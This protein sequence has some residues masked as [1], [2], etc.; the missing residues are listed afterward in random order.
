MEEFGGLVGEKTVRSPSCESTCACSTTSTGGCASSP[1]PL[2]GCC[3]MAASTTLAS[4]TFSF[5]WRPRLFAFEL[6]ISQS[7]LFPTKIL[8]F[9]LLE[10]D[11]LQ[12]DYTKLRFTTTLQNFLQNYLRVQPI[13][14]HE[15]R[16]KA[17]HR[18]KRR[19]KAILRWVSSTERP[20][21]LRWRLRR[22]SSASTA[23]SGSLLRHT[24]RQH[25]WPVPSNFVCRRR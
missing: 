22:G 17:T 14:M 3:S 12:N 11:W 1:L 21:S 4:T 24:S 15:M 25:R 16:L 9:E 13:V 8:R 20:P 18:N 7:V 2:S 19:L 23:S 6:Q 5:L 10:L